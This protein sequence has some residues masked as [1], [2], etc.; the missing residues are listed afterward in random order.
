MRGGGENAKGGAEHFYD[1]KV[2]LVCEGKSASWTVLEGADAGASESVAYTQGEP[3]NAKPDRH[4]YIFAFNESDNNSAPGDHIKSVMKLYSFKISENGQLVRDFLPCRNASG[5]AGLYDPV[6]ERFYANAGTGAFIGSD[7]IPLPTDEVTV[8]VP[9]GFF[10]GKTV[11]GQAVT[12]LAQ[13][14]AY[15]YAAE[16]NGLKAWQNYAMGVDGT[17]AANAFDITYTKTSET[18]ITLKTPIAA[19]NAPAGSGLIVTYTLMKSTD[20]GATWSEVETG[21]STP[22]VSLPVTGIGTGDSLWKFKAV[23]AAP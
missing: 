17:V 12:T 18:S 1:R 9:M 22:A 14:Q 8:R 20:G 3:G 19:F 4:L 13:K 6:T 10:N 15:L 11:E 7:E 5:V 21:L 23:F 2:N 16:A